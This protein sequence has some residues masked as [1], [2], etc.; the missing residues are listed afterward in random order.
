[1]RKSK[2]LVPVDSFEAW[3]AAAFLRINGFRLQ[4]DDL[5]AY[6]FLIGLYETNDFRFN[7]LVKWLS[8]HATQIG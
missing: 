1:L 7:R 6:A 2:A 4:F 8:R 5:K 3:V